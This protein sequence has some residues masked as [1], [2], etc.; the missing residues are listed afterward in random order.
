MT[1][2]HLTWREGEIT[3]SS[4]VKHNFTHSITHTLVSMFYIFKN[5]NSVWFISSFPHGDQKKKVPTRSKKLSFN[6][7]FFF[8]SNSWQIFPFLLKLVIG[9]MNFFEFKFIWIPIPLNFSSS[10]CS[11]SKF[12]RNSNS[13]K[14]YQFKK[15]LINFRI[16]NSK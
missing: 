13:T 6:Q 2:R 5:F 4:I 7:I 10:S 8:F 1:T 3:Q 11:N 12:N 14:I 15:H 16:K 9:I